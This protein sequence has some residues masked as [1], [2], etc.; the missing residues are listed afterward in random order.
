MSSCLWLRT[1]LMY[2]FLCIENT[3]R[4]T[5]ASLHAHACAHT[6]THLY[7]NI[8]TP[9]HKHAQRNTHAHTHTPLYT[10]MHRETHTHK[11]L[12][13]NIH[14]ETHTHTP[15]MIREPA[16]TAE[17]LT[18]FWLIFLSPYFHSVAGQTLHSLFAHTVLQTI[19]TFN[20]ETVLLMIWLWKQFTILVVLTLSVRCFN[21]ME[22]VMCVINY[23]SFIC[24]FVTDYLFMVSLLM[25]AQG[26]YSGT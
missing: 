5:F 11:H 7:T 18:Q 20:A 19:A 3:H 13:T 15:L 17:M 24:L 2:I 26:V 9:V 14:R 21:I 10:N 25:R 22:V 23:H 4:N 16:P 8:H 12:Y 6:H 1:F